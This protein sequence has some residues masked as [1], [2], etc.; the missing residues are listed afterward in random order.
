VVAIPAQLEQELTD[1][2]LR[3]A[4]DEENCFGGHRRD[5]DDAGSILHY[6]GQH[7]SAA[8]GSAE[9]VG[10]PDDRWD[11][12]GY[13]FGIETRNSLPVDEQAIAPEHDRRFDPLAL[14]NRSHEISDARQLAFLPTSA[15]EARDREIRSQ[16]LITA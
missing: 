5:D 6:G 8:D 15:R 4:E 12:R 1:V 13:A 3:R 9:L 7:L 2:R 14:S 16:A 11:E 10:G